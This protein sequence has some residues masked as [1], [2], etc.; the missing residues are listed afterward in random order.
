MK[1]E[2]RGAPASHTESDLTGVRDTS[3]RQRA[4]RWRT[5]HAEGC[6]AARLL[7]GPASLGVCAMFVA[8]GFASS[9]AASPRSTYTTSRRATPSSSPLSLPGVPLGSHLMFMA[10]TGSGSRTV[11]SFTADGGFQVRWRCAGPGLITETMS[12][13]RGSGGSATSPC[14]GVEHVDNYESECANAS[15]TIRFTAASTARWTCDAISE[16]SASN[17]EVCRS[18][19]PS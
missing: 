16:L 2:K 1:A 15:V 3:R 6:F 14:D 11:A 10:R 17:Q 5:P 18:S 9:P 8:C 19:S 7:I 12:D 4:C 13:T